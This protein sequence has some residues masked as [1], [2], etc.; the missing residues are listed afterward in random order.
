[1]EVLA[2][3]KGISRWPKT[4]RGPIGPSSVDRK[5]RLVPPPPAAEPLIIHTLTSAEHER[6]RPEAMGQERQDVI[7]DRIHQMSGS[8]SSSLSPCTL[9]SWPSLLKDAAPPSRG[10]VY[11]SPR[12]S[13]SVAG[14]MKTTTQD[15][16][17]WPGLDGDPPHHQDLTKE[18]HVIFMAMPIALLLGLGP[19]F[20]SC[21]SLS[22]RVRMGLFQMALQV[23]FLGLQGL[24][25]FLHLFEAAFLLGRELLRSLAP[26]LRLRIRF[27]RAEMDGVNPATFNA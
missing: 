9:S 11:S 16:I 14:G 23:S 20:S 19:P 18:L 13:L 1:M 4:E 24:L 27:A 10:V 3:C 6:P 17:P 15:F 22:L 26:G 8:S 12:S 25:L 7:K 21:H 2:R 5:P